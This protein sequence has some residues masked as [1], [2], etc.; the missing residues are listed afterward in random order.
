MFNFMRKQ[1]T[2]SDTTPSVVPGQGKLMTP[3]TKAQKDPTRAVLAMLVDRSGSM[4]SM[5]NEVSSGC[6]EYLDTQRETDTENKTTTHVLFSTFDQ[7]YELI[8]NATLSEQPK[9]T[10]KEV[11]PRGMTALYDSIAQT[12]SDTIKTLEKMDVAPAQVGV[13]ILTDGH[14]N[15]SHTWTKELI[16]AQIK[17]LESAPY[18]WQFYFAAAN[19]DAME[20][21]SS[22]GMKASQ[23]MTYRNDR[24]QMK[25]AFK[26]ASYAYSRQKKG[27]PTSFTPKERH[28]CT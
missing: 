1:V 23:C 13:F 26:G 24:E 9:I 8:R 5:G 17:L 4:N 19:Q 2:S 15:S 10:N 6:N 25:N 21:G 14:E 28:D 18:N 7:Q 27:G 16:A 20:V 11:E 22:I 3:P 12:I